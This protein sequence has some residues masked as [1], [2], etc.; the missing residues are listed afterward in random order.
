MI[1]SGRAAVVS[2]VIDPRFVTTG[3]LYVV[4]VANHRVLVYDQA[5]QN[6]PPI[7]S[8]TV[9]L[10]DPV[11][12]AVARNGDL[13]VGDGNGTIP[14]YHHGDSVPYMT[15][16]GTGS[17]I[18]ALTVDSH[19]TVYATQQGTGVVNR[20]I[21]VYA[22]GSITPTSSLTTPEAARNVATDSRDNLFVQMFYANT[23]VSPTVEFFVGHT[24]PVWLKVTAY[25]P[26]GVTVDGSDNLIVCDGGG[27]DGFNGS[28]SV[29]APPYYAAPLYSRRTFNGIYACAAN[30]AKDV[31]WVV[32]SG[33]SSAAIA[34]K[35][36]K[37]VDEITRGVKNPRAVAADSF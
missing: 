10:T 3:L 7:G 12:L 13:L 8:I 28:F 27:E 19:G 15:L 11:G 18:G 1:A 30:R 26:G 34:F 14:V 16:T 4:D 6:Q 33:N 32:G 35:R 23:V 2:H 37:W 31:T 36:S 29:Y 24:A 21:L 20:T 25:T 9:G 5:G 17:S 22:S